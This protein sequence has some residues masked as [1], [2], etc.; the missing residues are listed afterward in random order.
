[1]IGRS[2]NKEKKGVEPNSSCLEL[3]AQ[4]RSRN[5]AAD[6]EEKETAS[7]LSGGKN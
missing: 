3:I 7:Y 1:M 2:S 4:T 6:L 5:L